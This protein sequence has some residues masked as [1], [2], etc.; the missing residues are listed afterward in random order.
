[1]NASAEL[2]D[3]SR[4]PPISVRDWW[5]PSFLGLVPTGENARHILSRK[6]A[7]QDRAAQQ[8]M[9]HHEMH[10]NH[11]RCTAVSSYSRK[12]DDHRE[13]GSCA[14]RRTHA[15]SPCNRFFRVFRVFRGSH[16]Q[17]SIGPKPSCRGA[18]RNICPGKPPRWPCPPPTA[19]SRWSG[20]KRMPPSTK[21]LTAPR[22][23]L[24]SPK[25]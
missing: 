25:N 15:P 22:W 19:T 18:S 8:R 14:G 1:M 13:T 10:E 6:G 12:T 16:R 11:E 2:T 17:R 24:R 5:T 9:I 3:E 7:V 4:N 20:S 23:T 21:P